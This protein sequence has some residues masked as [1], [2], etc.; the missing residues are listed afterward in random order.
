MTSVFI[1]VQYLLGS[2]NGALISYGQ[3]TLFMHSIL[4]TTLDNDTY[5]GEPL[6]GDDAF[7]H[8]PGLPL[9]TI[10]SLK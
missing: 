7:S 2:L 8:V 6:K 3:F 9:G 5:N 10:T 4:C 1:E